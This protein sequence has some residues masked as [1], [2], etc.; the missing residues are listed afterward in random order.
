[1][2]DEE[3]AEGSSGTEGT[4]ESGAAAGGGGEGERGDAAEVYAENERLREENVA[5]AEQN[6]EL[7]E[8]MSEEGELRTEL[9]E[10]RSQ[11]EALGQQVRA[12]NI[13][14]AR[15]EILREQPELREHLELIGE[16]D[17]GE[18]RKRAEKLKK[19]SE[20][21]VAASRGALE[22]EIA[23]KFGVPLGSS[24]E[25]EVTAEEAAKRREAVDAGD[26]SAVAAQIV[27][28]ELDKLM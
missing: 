4:G 2:A 23:G 12:G 20:A 18:M 25:G 15:E 10:E 5:L 17:P 22:K 28:G 14:R 1:M 3:R 9:A 8:G 26:A 13:D 11:R 21:S 27:E 19:F 24:T 7:V 16:D 6:R